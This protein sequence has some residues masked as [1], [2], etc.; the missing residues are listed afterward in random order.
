MWLVISCLKWLGVI[1][2][3][4]IG[5]LLLTIVIDVV[6]ASLGVN[7]NDS[8]NGFITLIIIALGCINHGRREFRKRREHKESSLPS[9]GD[10]QHFEENIR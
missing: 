9:E 7:F 10:R 3:Y 6:F 4:Y 8:A 1:V 2:G 5:G